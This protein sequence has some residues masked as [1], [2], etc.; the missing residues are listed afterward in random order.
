MLISCHIPKT[1]GVSF[2][3]ALREAYGDRFLWDRSHATIGAA[4]WADKRIP[5]ESVAVRWLDRYQRPPLRGISCLHGHFPLRKF[6]PLAFNRNNVFVVWLREPLRWRISLYYYWKEAYP[7]PTNRLLN[8]VFDENWDLERFCLDRTYNNHQSLFLAWFPWYRINFI[9]VT[10]NYASDLTYLSQSILH[11]EL[12]LHNMNQSRKPE[13]LP[14]EDFGSQFFRRFESSNRLDYRNY[15]AA[16]R[17]SDKRA[18]DVRYLRVRGPF[19]PAAAASQ[20]H[21]RSPASP[22]P[23]TEPAGAVRQATNGDLPQE[24]LKSS[25]F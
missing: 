20:G 16:L 13:R 25:R 3:T 7:H 19:V 11:R 9:G 23:A 21:L 1:A 14:Q 22:A 24:Q 4:M 12:N 8:R 5:P 10:D 2:A 6:L 18:A 15:R 17:V